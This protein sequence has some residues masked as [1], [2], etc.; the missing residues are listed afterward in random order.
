MVTTVTQSTNGH[1][2]VSELYNLT[3]L[4][5]AKRLVAQYG[6]NLHYCHPWG[7]WLSWDGSRWAVDRMGA[8]VRKA[9]DSLHTIYG[10]AA[11]M[12]DSKDRTARA[13]WAIQCESEHR[14]KAT[15]GLAKHQTGIPVLPEELD[16]NP[17]LFNV[18]DGTIDLSTGELLPSTASDLITKQAPVCFKGPIPEPRRWLQ[19]IDQITGG[20]TELAGHIQRAVGYSLTGLHDAQ[21]LFIAYGTGAN[22][23]STFLDTVL[24]I[25]GDYGHRAPPELLMR[26]KGGNRHPTE[27][28]LLFGRRFVPAVESGEG[29]SLDEAKVKELTGGD[30]ITA[31]GMRQDYWQFK[32]T[33]KLWLATNHLPRIRGTDESI[34]RRICVIPFTVTFDENQREVRSVL[35]AQLWA[36][37]SGI[38]KWLV[39]G[40]L[41]YQAVG[42]LKPNVVLEASGEYRKGQDVLRNFLEEYCYIGGA[43]RATVDDTFKAYREWGEASGERYLM[44]K[45]D[46]GRALSERGYQ[47]GRT[48]QFWYWDGLG[49]LQDKA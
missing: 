32:P 4:G 20:D 15:L 35:D 49:L 47:K 5:N 10:E 30:V 13:T 16:V 44:G 17:M 27:R 46:F 36:E 12:E 43:A 34:W 18:L 23:K 24:T 41:A 33:H 21:S 29:K 2:G 14:I 19:F 3:E 9:Q 37:R 11:A 25:T 38:L 45:I 31:R 28:A 26:D 39:D 7:Q 48:G 6:H 42:L 22:G 40:C 1:K 8:V